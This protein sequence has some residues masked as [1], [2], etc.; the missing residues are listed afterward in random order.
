MQG[1]RV[2]RSWDTRFYEETMKYN[3]FCRIKLKLG[4]QPLSLMVKIVEFQIVLKFLL[5][6]DTC[7]LSRE[8]MH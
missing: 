2:P 3:F 8:I 5:N 6:N 1:Y 7:R 4:E